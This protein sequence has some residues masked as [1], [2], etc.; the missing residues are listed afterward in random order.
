MRLATI[1][2]LKRFLNKSSSTSS[3]ILA[4]ILE[5]SIEI[6]LTFLT[7]SINYIKKNGEF[8]DL[9]SQKLVFYIKRRIP[10]RRKT[11]NQ[12]AY[13]HVYGRFLSGSYI[14]K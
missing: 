12:S 11:T 13:C 2:N 3:S 4:A 9:E 5:L 7:N 10:Y 1:L 6:H 14:N 8:P